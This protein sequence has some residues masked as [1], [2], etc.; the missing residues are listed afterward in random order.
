[1]RIATFVGAQH[2]A[3]L[4]RGNVVQSGSIGAIVRS[5]KSAVA[6]IVNAQQLTDG[7]PLWQRNY[8]EHVI[9]KHEDINRIRQYIMD[10]PKNWATDPENP[11]I[12]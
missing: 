11:F 8:Y 10:N 7:R 9:R 2:A 12:S 3:P 4:Q 1:M 6:K 5:F